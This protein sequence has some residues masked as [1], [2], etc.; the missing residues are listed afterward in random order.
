MAKQDKKWQQF[1]ETSWQARADILRDYIKDGLLPVQAIYH[2]ETTRRRLEL[3][4]DEDEG[5]TKYMPIAP[6]KAN[7]VSGTNMMRQTS[8]NG[9][10][11][12]VSQY[13]SFDMLSFIID[14]INQANRRAPVSSITELGCGMGQNIIKM[15]YAGAPVKLPYFGG[16]FTESGV[17]IAMEMADLTPNLNAK[18]FH[19]NHLKPRIDEDLGE[20]AFIFTIHTIEQ[21][22]LI[23]NNW[24]E[25][26]AKSAKR[27]TCVHF[28]PFGWQFKILGEA[29]QEQARNFYKNSWNQNMYEV[30]Q[31]SAK[32][33][34]ID[35]K[36][37]E[38]EPTLPSDPYN[39]SS[40]AVWY[41]G[42]DGE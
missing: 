18:F 12:Q 32:K 20:H 36:Y 22:Q 37:I 26:V 3:V 9:S 11:G 7:I 35:I 25:V 4:F 6:D 10:V 28:E 29:S 40:I 14:C 31:K 30:M 16:E 23:P 41:S 13:A 17:K 19:F 8:L 15:F 5:E 39:P 34:V 33:G 38:L 42:D 2:L 24:F 27:V 1:Y 21:V